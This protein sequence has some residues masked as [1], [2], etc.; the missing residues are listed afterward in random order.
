MD[1][2]RET[3]LLPEVLVHRPLPTVHQIKVPGSGVRDGET[4]HFGHGAGVITV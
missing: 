1:V 4:E 3:W 2:A